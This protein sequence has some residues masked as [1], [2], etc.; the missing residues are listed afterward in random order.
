MGEKPKRGRIPKEKEIK[1][2]QDIRDLASKGTMN[3]KEI[4]KLVGTS[5]HYVGKVLKDFDI[6]LDHL[7]VYKDKAND[8]WADKERIIMQQIT[9]EKAK[10]ASLQQLVTSA[11]ICKDKRTE[12]LGGIQPAGFTQLVLNVDKVFMERSKDVAPIIRVEPIPPEDKDIPD[13]ERLPI[14]HALGVLPG[15]AHDECPDPGGGVPGMPVP[16]EKIIDITPVSDAPKQ[17]RSRRKKK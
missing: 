14:D 8:I 13:D 10:K 3:R 12:K 11:A 5:E 1:I 7:R 6:N 2:K 17:K 9:A 16:R 4:G 15:G